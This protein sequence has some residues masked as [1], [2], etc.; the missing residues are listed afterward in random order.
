M[1][2][3]PLRAEFLLTGMAFLMATFGLLEAIHV[4][5]S[6]SLLGGS[7]RSLEIGSFAL[8]IVVAYVIGIVIVQLTFFFPTQL[9]IVGVRNSRF[10]DLRLLDEHFN[11]PTRNLTDPESALADTNKSFL[12]AAAPAH[13]LPLAFSREATWTAYRVP[14]LLRSRVVTLQKRS[15][16]NR[17]VQRFINLLDA[18]TPAITADEVRVELAEA[19]VR[20]AQTL[21]LT[22]GRSLASPEVTEEYKYRR[23]NR[24]IFV[25]ML[26]AGVAAGLA[27]TIALGHHSMLWAPV[28][29]VLTIVGLC[30]LWQSAAYQERIAQSLIVDVAFLERWKAPPRDV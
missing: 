19:R 22:I 28:M 16:N 14:A 12:T 13:V 10:R 11:D 20:H 5:A 8:I 3:N 6:R 29:V 23:A 24:Q 1:S 30:V 25:G 18:R 7:V 21:A 15:N 2:T 17:H 9:M 26:P 27:S 4:D